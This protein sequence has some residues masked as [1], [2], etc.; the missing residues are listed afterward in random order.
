MFIPSQKKK[1]KFS[2]LFCVWQ[3]FTTFLHFIKYI[4]NIFL[5]HFI[6]ANEFLKIHNV[7]LL[8]FLFN[9]SPKFFMSCK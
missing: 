8:F 1:N 5:I 2:L 9:Y 3:K 7:L 6:I 4:D